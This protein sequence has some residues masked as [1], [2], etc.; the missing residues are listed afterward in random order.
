[1]INFKNDYSQI[2]HKNI[3]EVMLK[4]SGEANVGYGLDYHS[5]NAANL[6]K[7]QINSINQVVNGIKKKMNIGLVKNHIYSIDQAVN[8]LKKS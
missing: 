6:I 2:A 1:M 7:N 3:L 8:G 4:Y 5:Q